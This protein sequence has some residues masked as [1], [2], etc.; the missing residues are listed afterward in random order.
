MSNDDPR[1]LAHTTR[2]HPGE[3]I[4]DSR[5]WPGLILVALGMAA[6]GLTLTGAGYGFAGWAWIGAAV[7][8]TCLVL[9]ASLVV[10]EH[11]RV[12]K[13]DGAGLAVQFGH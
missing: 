10:A 1:D 4:E 6:L 12:K 8:A 2:E 11:R 5:N 3:S 7:C 13:L 9:G